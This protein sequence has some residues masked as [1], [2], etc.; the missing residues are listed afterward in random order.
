MKTECRR[1][2]REGSDEMKDPV[3]CN[4]GMDLNG[5]NLVW[6]RFSVAAGKGKVAPVL[7]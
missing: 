5:P 4:L 7:N 6:R 2:F 3:L 1:G